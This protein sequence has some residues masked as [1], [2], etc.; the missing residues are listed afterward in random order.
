MLIDS[1]CHLNLLTKD[2]DLD[3][4]IQRALENNVQY[5]QT[6]CT[7]L[8]DF[9]IVLEIAEKYENVF[10][11]V[12]VHPCEVNSSISHCEALQV[13]WQSQE[14]WKRLPRQDYVFP[15]SDAE[16]IIKLTKH[17]K[18]IGI[19]E[20]GLDYYHEP[21]D[22]KL[23]KDSFV[24]H[25]HAAAATNIPIIVHTREADEDTIDILTSEMRN[26]K[27]PGLIHCFTSSKN[28]ATKMLDI[29][30]YIS[31]S[32]IITF[33]NATDLQEIVKY[34][35]LDRLLIETDTPYLAPTPMRGKQNE[36]AFV[37]YVVEKVAELKNITSKEVANITTRNFKILFSKF[38]KYVNNTL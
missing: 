27:F 30:L 4:V 10:A 8:E 7:K 5:M 2:T 3:S 19:G 32:G 12:G 29:G 35:P 6:I 15:S 18:I 38:E 36:P 24:A 37:R 26:S 33:K 20:T 11:S 17:P 28:L 22:K 34:V 21:Y 1:H 31:M 23:Q 16:V 14:A 25:I 13:L 9:P